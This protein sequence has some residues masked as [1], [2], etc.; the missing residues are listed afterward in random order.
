MQI[1]RNHSLTNILTRW[2]EVKE[3]IV[4]AYLYVSCMCVCVCV[5][6]CV[7]VRAHK[8]DI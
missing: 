4:G 2:E 5:C 6:V 3:L 7:R 1:F 8:E